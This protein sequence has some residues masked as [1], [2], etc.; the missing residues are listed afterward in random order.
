MGISSSWFVDT[1]SRSSARVKLFCFPYAGGS[2]AIYRPW[3]TLL[4]PEIQLIPVELPGRGARMKERAFRNLHL[5]V[6]A[7]VEAFAPLI[8]E[9]FVLFGHSMGALIAFELA[10]ELRRRGKAQPRRLLVSGRRAPQLSETGKQLYDLPEPEFIEELHNLNGTPREVLE[11]EEL[12]ALMIPMLRADFELIE[13]YEY[14]REPPLECPITVY[15]GIEDT[16]VPRTCLSSWKEHTSAAFAIHMLAGDHFFLR[17]A[18]S[19]LLT[20]ISAELRR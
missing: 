17:S 7:L 10:R 18:R 13:T 9:D 20:M 16:E 4:P 3:A 14:H 11:H 1:K 19:E 12:M 8:E 6:Q 5:L 15:G 2:A